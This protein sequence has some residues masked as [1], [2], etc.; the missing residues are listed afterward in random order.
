MK[1]SKIEDQKCEIIFIVES[2]LTSKPS[3]KK[4]S[5][6]KYSTPLRDLQI[7]RKKKKSEEKK[8]RDK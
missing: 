3:V 7:Q 8:R 2:K 5:E 4:K 1:I 6:G